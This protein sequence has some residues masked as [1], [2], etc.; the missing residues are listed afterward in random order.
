MNIQSYVATGYGTS[1]PIQDN[2]PTESYTIGEKTLESNRKAKSGYGSGA[3]SGYGSGA[4]SE[5]PLTKVSYDG[6]D[7]EDWGTADGGDDWGKE[8]DDDW[9]KGGDD[10]WGK[11]N[12]DWGFND[13][14]S[15]RSKA[16]STRK[17][18]D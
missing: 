9:G 12:G 2:E 16:S 4:Q 8:G 6:W 18:G 13:S 7:N 1:K 5:N 10:G 14:K 3:Q 11:D 17:K 15:S